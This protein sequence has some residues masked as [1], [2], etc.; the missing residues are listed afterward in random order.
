MRQAVSRLSKD[1]ILKVLK[2]FW[3]IEDWENKSISDNDLE[4]PATSERPAIYYDGI[5]G[6]L[7]LEYPSDEPLPD[8]YSEQAYPDLNWEIRS[9][10]DIDKL[11]DYL[12]EEEVEDIKKTCGNDLDCILDRAYELI[13]NKIEKELEEEIR[14]IE[15]SKP[16]RKRFCGVPVVKKLDIYEKTDYTDIPHT[17]YYPSEVYVIPLDKIPDERTI[18]CVIEQI[19]NDF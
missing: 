16:E 6:K 11:Y 7:I 9:L 3:D 15:N 5:E 19:R 13:G 18:E 12:D 17:V 8:P 1:D 10:K 4:F 14:R 2:K